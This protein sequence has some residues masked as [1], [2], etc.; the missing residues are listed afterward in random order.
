MKE[1]VC[2]TCHEHYED[3]KNKESIRKTGLCVECFE[4]F[5]RWEGEGGHI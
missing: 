5:T 2:P 4:E 3:S 1:N